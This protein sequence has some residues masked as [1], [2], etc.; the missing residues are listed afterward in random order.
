M[1]EDIERSVKAKESQEWSSE[2]NE[3]LLDFY[4]DNDQLWNH[5][6]Q[7][8]RDRNLREVNMKS[9]T[10][11]FP[12]RSVDEIKKQWQ[13]LKTI[14]LREL[15]REEG[16]KST[17]T[18]TNTVYVSN[19]KHFKSMRFVKGSDDLDPQ[20]STLHHDTENEKPI[21]RARSNSKHETPTKEIEEAKLGLYR[22]A[23]R[24]LQM[25]LPVGPTTPQLTVEND[26]I[27][28]FLKNIETTLRRFPGR[29]LTLAKR[30]IYEVVS[31]L[32]LEF[33]DHLLYDNPPTP[34][35][36]STVATPTGAPLSEITPNMSWPY[37]TNN[38]FCL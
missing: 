18:G 7:S 6:L 32:E 16:S 2:D 11:L 31:D 24:C 35:S 23:I 29:H 26:D 27:T 10:E 34:I 13:I 3:K 5:N 30:K 33:Y 1:K 25:P 28:M 17:G 22:E 19:W 14:F 37:N 12:E 15:K 4:R 36:N 9:L 38:S 8:Y 21:K 20:V